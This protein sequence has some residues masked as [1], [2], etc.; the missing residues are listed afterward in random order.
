MSQEQ[1][2]QRATMALSHFEAR[3]R[4]LLH[5]A[6]EAREELEAPAEVFD[7]QDQGDSDDEPPV[8]I[9]IADGR[10]TRIKVI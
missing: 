5:E 3:L 9:G 1:R 6:V 8:I 2:L 7:G 10:T 4:R